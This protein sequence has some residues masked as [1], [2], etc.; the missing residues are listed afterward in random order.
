MKCT[1]VSHF[2][3]QNLGDLLLSECLYQIVGSVCDTRRVA[4]GRNP[5]HFGDLEAISATRLSLPKRA[6][7]RT[8]RWMSWAGLDQGARIVDRVHGIR[9]GADED[10]ERLRR[11]LIPLFM[12]A[13]LI[14]LGGGNLL[15]DLQLSSSSS[16]SVEIYFDLAEELGKPVF[17]SSI[18]IGPFA[19]KQQ[20]LD[21]IRLLDRADYI[22]FRDNDSMEILANH[23]TASSKTLVC[24]DPAFLLEQR[25]GSRGGERIVGLNL[26]DPDLLNLD[27][28]Q[29]KR[30]LRGYDLLVDRLSESNH[31]VL[32]STDLS[33]YNHLRRLSRKFRASTV[34]L[35]NI[36][37]LTNLLDLY[38][39]TDVL[40][41]CRMHSMI[42]AFTQSVPV[43]GL[44]WQP[45]VK[46]FFDI[47]RAPKYCFPFDNVVE[48]LDDILNA[49]ESRRDRRHSESLLNAQ[50]LSEI[51]AAIEVQTQ[52]VQSYKI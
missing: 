44:A 20:E 32:F 42:I 46:G 50:R 39:S 47:T 38:A 49:V 14:V 16:R 26:I 33:D 51:R 8:L 21:A 27:Y 31:V 29:T 37:G 23:R 6:L 3:S 10:R 11:T 24:P 7:Q 28:T 34:S 18:G 30:I 40:I 52:I 13:D 1:L 15:F 17:V 4:L 5:L 35:R 2:D 41:C 19:T 25:I 45:K 9:S 43:V 22:T 48:Q 36:S 12:D